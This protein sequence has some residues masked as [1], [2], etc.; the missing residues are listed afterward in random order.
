MSNEKDYPSFYDWEMRNSK[1]NIK[2][3]IKARDI[4]IIKDED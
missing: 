3:Y 1:D 4:K 2:S